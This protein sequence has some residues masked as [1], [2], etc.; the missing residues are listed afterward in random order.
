MSGFDLALDA[1]RKHTLHAK[2]R[3]AAH[4]DVFI[5][6][7]IA[8]MK[9]VDDLHYK[10]MEDLFV[11]FMRKHEAEAAVVLPMQKKDKEEEEDFFSAPVAMR[12]RTIDA[13]ESPSSSSSSDEEYDCSESEKEKKHRH[14]NV[15]DDVLILDDDDEEE[16][17]SFVASDEEKPVVY[18]AK[19]MDES[20]LK[21]FRIGEKRKRNKRKVWSPSDHDGERDTGPAIDL[22]ADAKAS[23]VKSDARSLKYF[24]QD[25]RSE[26]FAEA[27][28]RSPWY[29]KRYGNALEG[30][31]NNLGAEGS[32]TKARTVFN[33]LMHQCMNDQDA[34]P[35]VETKKTPG[36][37]PK[38]CCLCDKKKHCP[39]TL[40]L[41]RVFE[42]RQS[43]HPIAVCCSQL[44]RAVIEFFSNMFLLVQDKSVKSFEQAF[45]E[46]ERLFASI[47]S[48]HA[49][50]AD[51]KK[52][53]Q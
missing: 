11:A 42:D 8:H 3:H 36:S 13:V 20:L 34:D 41:K 23:D 44:A 25:I 5:N 28:Q 17:D 38:I 26:G 45:L 18:S 40:W 15:D 27:A 24:V 49:G 14:K 19:V 2:E 35:V 31:I 37:G 32:N 22:L 16:Q 30:I 7:M 50:K 39:H 4:R 47:Q 6:D 46:S 52:H 29:K 10:E 1:F 21:S 53:K 51:L 48:A 12:K 9:R 33:L 43:S